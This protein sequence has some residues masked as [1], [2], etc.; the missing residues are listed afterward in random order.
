M[1]AGYRRVT[2]RGEAR[3]PM[4]RA[5]RAAPRRRPAGRRAEAAGTIRVPREV[6]PRAWRRARPGRRRRTASPKPSAT[7]PATTPGAG[8][9]GWPPTRRA[10]PTAARCALGSSRRRV[11]R[12]RAGDARRSAVPD[13]SASRHPRPPQAHGR[14]SGSTITWPMWPALPSAPSSSRPSSTMPPPTPVDTTMA[15]KLRLARRR[16]EPALAERRAPWRRCRRTSAG[17]CARPAARRSGKSRQAGMLSGDTASPPGVIG[18][19]QPDPARDDA[20]PVAAP[21]R[22]RLVEQRR[23]RRPNSASASRRATVRRRCRR[24]QD[25]AARRSTRPA[26]SFVPPMSTASTTSTGGTDRASRRGARPARRPLRPSTGLRWPFRPRS[27]RPSWPRESTAPAPGR[28]VERPATERSPSCSARSPTTSSGSSR[29]RP[30]SSSSRSL[31]LRR[32]GPPAHRG[33]AR[34]GQDQPGQGAGRVDRLHVRPHA[35]HPRPA[36][37]RRRRR[38]RVEPRRPASSSSA[39]ARS[40]PT[41]CSATRSTGPRRRRSRRC[42]R[43][44]TSARSPST[45]RP[46]RSTPP[47]MVIATQNPI[48]HEGTYPLPESQLDRFLMRVVVGYPDRDAELEILDTHGD[49]DAARRPRPGRHRRRR[50]GDDRRGARRA[51]GAEPQGLPRRPGRGDPP[52]PAPRPR[53]VAPRHARPAA[54][55]PGPGRRARAHLR[56]PRRHQG[57][58]RAGARPPPAASRP[59]PS[60]RAPPRPTSLDEVLASV[61]VPSGRTA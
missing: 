34:R 18:P 16:A 60:C 32:R 10:R 17:R 19:P 43:P 36:A 47:F 14:P 57:A 49:H 23:R 31:C 25:P 11:L 48:E 58:G 21:R 52:P 51:R 6:E 29:A 27:S 24:R 7:E 54:G 59:R 40:S 41:S 28:P 55:R 5:A 13:A 39:P 53:H 46:T 50:P 33:R 38:D 37:V 61:P 30:R 44:W 12:R 42:S 3:A 8:R 4:R 26:A 20:V 56:R 9:A 15:M 1:S 22:T 35:V 2:G 45:A